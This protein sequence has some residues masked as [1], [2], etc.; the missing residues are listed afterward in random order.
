MTIEERLRQL[1]A[2]LPSKYSAV[3]L[4]RE[5]IVS[6]LDSEPLALEMKTRDMSVEKVA[7]E[8]GRAPST[9]RGWLIAGEL[10][11]YKLNGK[12]WRVPRAALREYL[13]AQTTSSP[14]PQRP[15]GEVDIRAWRAVR[16]LEK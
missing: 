15:T 5:D 10:R 11:G 8:V 3:S 12:S 6:L 7:E 13:E 14:T 1:A 9:V 16:G 2:A 4:T